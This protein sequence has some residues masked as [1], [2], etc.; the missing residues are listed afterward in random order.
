MEIYDVLLSLTSSISSLGESVNF[1]NHMLLTNCL[2]FV[3]AFKGEIKIRLVNFKKCE[4]HLATS[5][6]GH[7]ADFCNQY[8]CYMKLEFFVSRLGAVPHLC[9]NGSSELRVMCRPIRAVRGC[10]VPC[11]AHLLL[12]SSRGF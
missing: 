6:N 11:S 3:S 1:F 12:A 9:R 5:R 4:F 7:I 10:D 8:L 2:S